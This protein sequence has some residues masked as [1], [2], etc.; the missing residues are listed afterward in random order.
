MRNKTTNGQFAKVDPEIRFNEKV[1]KSESCWIWNG[2]K[3]SKGY[4]RLLISGKRIPAHRLA[5]EYVKGNIPDNFQID[6]LCRNPSCVNPDHLEAVTQK[7]NILRGISP[8]AIKARMTKCKRGHL[9][10]RKAPNGQRVCSICKRDN[11]QIFRAK[12]IER[13]RAKGK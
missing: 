3:D 8:S 10:D 13:L 2:W 4:G 6:H 1:L 9:F 11:Y 12:N 5:Y 7:V